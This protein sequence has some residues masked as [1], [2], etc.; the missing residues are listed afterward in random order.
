VLN[1]ITP[2]KKKSDSNHDTCQLLMDDTF[3]LKKQL[4]AYDQ[5]F[6]YLNMLKIR[7]EELAKTQEMLGRRLAEVLESC[8]D[9]VKTQ[10]ARV[11]EVEEQVRGYRKEGEKVEKRVAEFIR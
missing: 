10:V 11:D 5:Q 1:L 9:M 2:Y 4:S 3:R 6:K 8:N 7:Q